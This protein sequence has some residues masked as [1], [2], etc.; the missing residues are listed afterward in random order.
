MRAK[1]YHIELVFLNKYNLIIFIIIIQILWLLTYDNKNCILLN[2]LKNR[3]ITYSD[4][5]IPQM[6]NIFVEKNK[7][8][9]E[10]IMLKVIIHW[11]F[12]SPFLIDI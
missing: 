1:I 12:S 10:E 7:K 5:W 4:L 2:N 3:N 9:I 6:L 8:I 11:P